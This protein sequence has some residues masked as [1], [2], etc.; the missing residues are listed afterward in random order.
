M[1]HFGSH[2]LA[3]WE[4]ARS[5]CN[6]SSG[7]LF[8]AGS[9]PSPVCPPAHCR[10]SQEAGIHLDFDL[11]FNLGF[12]LRFSSSFPN[13]FNSTLSLLCQGTGN[14]FLLRILPSPHFFREKKSWNFRCESTL[15]I[16]GLDRIICTTC[17]ILLLQ[18]IGSPSVSSINWLQMSSFYF[19]NALSTYCWCPI[20]PWG[21]K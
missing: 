19:F 4:G 17:S 16:A 10:C 1:I 14:S 15:N 11:G 8:P 12:N 20:W 18:K 3:A 9:V 13:V 7:I 5:P 2:T 21:L 6:T